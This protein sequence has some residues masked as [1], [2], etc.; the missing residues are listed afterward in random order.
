[1]SV[2]FHMITLNSAACSQRDHSQVNQERR[3]PYQNEIPTFLHVAMEW[4][5]R[6]THPLPRGGTDLMGPRQEWPRIAE[7]QLNR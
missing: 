2:S 5:A 1:V 7:R 3:N 6:I 4:L